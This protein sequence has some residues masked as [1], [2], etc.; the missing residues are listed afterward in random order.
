MM[1]F[2]ATFLYSSAMWDEK[3]VYPK[4]E[5]GFASKPHMIDVNV[6]AFNDQTFNHDG[7]ESAIFKTKKYNP[8]NFMFQHLPVKEEVK[9]IEFNRMRNGYI[10]DTLTSVDFQEVF[11]IGGKVIQNNKGVIY[12]ENF[13]IS[14]SK[15]VF[16][17]LFA[18]RQKYKDEGN[19]LMQGL[20]KII[21]NG[22]FGVQIRR[23]IIES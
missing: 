23:D 3:S 7:D 17:K 4:V 12:W 5:T 13:K 20:V 1:D 18:L 2:D 14:P 8:S 21:M 15:E 22:L 19:D 6:K 9:I 16:E 10:K 11:K